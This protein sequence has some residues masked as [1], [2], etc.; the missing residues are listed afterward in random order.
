MELLQEFNPLPMHAELTRK[1]RTDNLQK[2]KDNECK[3]LIANGTAKHGLNVKDI[4][5]IIYLRAGKSPVWLNQIIGRGLRL[6]TQGEQEFDVVDP[7]DNIYIFRQQSDARI[8][9]YDTEGYTIKRL[10]FELI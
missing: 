9:L 10:K 2:F 4:N 5:C 3:V 6:K 8:A 1:A 7:Y